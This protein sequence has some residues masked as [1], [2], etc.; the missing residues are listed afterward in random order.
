ML[1]RVQK[2][3]SH[4]RSQANSS[5]TSQKREVE[6]GR[7][8]IRNLLTR[9]HDLAKGIAERRERL[10]EIGVNL[11]RFEKLQTIY[12]SDIARLQTLE[13]AGFLLLIGT[14]KDC[15]LCGAPAAAQAHQHGADEIDQIRRGSLA[16]IA[17]NFPAG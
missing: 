3:G 1:R 9:K 6:A 12:A 13:E 16:E 4:L 14:D 7:D 10:A 8:S 2:M 15:P 11:S 17:K 5:N